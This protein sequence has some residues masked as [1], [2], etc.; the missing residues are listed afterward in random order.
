VVTF[1]EDRAEAFVSAP[2]NSSATFDV[3][4]RTTKKP[5]VTM[6]YLLSGDQEVA[7]DLTQEAFLRAWSRW[8][9][10]SKYDDPE[11]WTRRVLYNLIISRSRK[12]KIRRR[13]VESPRFAPP[14]DELHLLLAAAL[15]S[16]PDSQM[17]ALVLHDG[18]GLSV[19]EVA[20]EM[21]VP[22]GTVKSWMS[23]GRATAAER[24]TKSWSAEGD[25]HVD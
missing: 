3:F 7:Q 13:A 11:A 18:A 19:R 16:L 5:L 20:F 12:D 4:F 24:L 9:R 22:E 25:K 17:R 15:R 23:R 21:K 2:D 14:P 10:I 1:P 8:N 6:A